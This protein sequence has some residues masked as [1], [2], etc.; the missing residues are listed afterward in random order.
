VSPLFA[1]SQ[2][3]YAL[4]SFEPATMSKNQKRIKI[5]A[6]TQD[7]SDTSPEDTVALDPTYYGEKLDTSSKMDFTLESGIDNDITYGRTKQLKVTF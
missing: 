1:P 4:S 3:P 2:V 6:Y 7:T 5:D